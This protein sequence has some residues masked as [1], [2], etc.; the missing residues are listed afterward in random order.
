MSFISN[1]VNPGQSGMELI[2]A[3]YRRI[4]LKD[5]NNIPSFEELISIFGLMIRQG[6]GRDFE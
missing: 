2:A 1:R 6:I 3:D 4:F 5:N